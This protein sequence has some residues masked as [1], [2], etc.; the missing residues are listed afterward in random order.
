MDSTIRIRG[1]RTHNLK[2]VSLDLPRH[3]LVVVTGL[4]GSGKS[5]L[6]FDTLYAEGQ[7]RYVESLSA[8]ARQFLQLMDKPDVDLI[9]GLSPAISI[10]QKAAGHNPRSTVGTITEIHDYLRLLYAR[11]GT[12][13]C[14]DH[15]L[16]LQAQS[17]SQMVDA[18]MAWPADTRLA[19]LAPIARGK[20]GSF[21]DECASLQA[22][23]Y[24]RLRVDGQLLEI[25]GMA[26]LKKSEARHR[27]GD[28]PPAHQ[29]REQ[30]APGREFRNRL[31]TGRGPRAGAGHGQQPRTGLLQPLRLPGLQ[32]QPAGTGAAAVQLQQPDGRLPQL[33]RHRTGRIL[34][35]QARGR[36]PELSLAA[37]AIR[38]WDRRNAFTHSL[39]TSLAAHYEFE[40]EAPFEELPEDVRQKVLYGSG[41]EEISFVYLNERAAARSSATPSK[42]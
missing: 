5:S 23:G 40:I 3:K 30:A 19:V 17:V 16:P 1:A 7:R 24:V 15:G 34:R 6:A 12:P 2:N 13:Y 25:D 8:Y 27:R 10:E 20:K 9:E 41:D 22:Q 35:P 37:G 11:V 36:L 29:A 39:L 42:A 28:R 32:P 38:G 18:V 33:R 21:E 31:A 14:P 26:P 4:S